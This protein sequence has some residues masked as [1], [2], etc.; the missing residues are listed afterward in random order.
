MERRRQAQA[1]FVWSDR[2]H[3]PGYRFVAGLMESDSTWRPRY[4]RQEVLSTDQP[5]GVLFRW[6]TLEAIALLGSITAAEPRTVNASA[7]VNRKRNTPDLANLS[8]A[9]RDVEAHLTI[10]LGEA[11]ER[12]ETLMASDTRKAYVDE[13]NSSMPIRI[14][15]DEP[16]NTSSARWLSCTAP[17]SEELA[18]QQC[19][20]FLDSTIHASKTVEEASIWRSSLAALAAMEQSL[21]ATNPVDVVIRQEDSKV[22]VIG[23]LA[24]T[25]PSV[26]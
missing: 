15:D 10:G 25:P 14:V 26:A 6:R 13:L 3:H 4:L 17:S 24:T 11:V 8:I 1:L 9:Y 18:R 19:I 23:G 21:T 16:V 12:R 22:R 7:V 20:A 5:A 2:R